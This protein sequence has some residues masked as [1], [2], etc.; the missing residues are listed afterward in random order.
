M[1]D[2]ISFHSVPFRSVPAVGDEVTYNLDPLELSDD[3]QTVDLEVV[4]VEV[5]DAMHAE[6]WVTVHLEDPSGDVHELASWRS[7]FEDLCT[8]C[9]EWV[10]QGTTE[11]VQVSPTQ[12]EGAC[13]SCN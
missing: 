4:D 3:D 8:I 11:T 12:L 13:Q 9:G 1:S 7:Q 5:E 2:E 10:E 6:E